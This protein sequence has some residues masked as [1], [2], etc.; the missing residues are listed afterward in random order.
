MQYFCIV[1][2]L[3]C[4]LDML[5]LCVFNLFYRIFDFLRDSMHIDW[6]LFDF[7]LL[8]LNNLLVQQLYL[9]FEPLQ[10]IRRLHWD[11]NQVSRTF[12][13][14]K[15]QVAIR[16]AS[17]QGR[18]SFHWR[19]NRL[20]LSL[21]HV[22]FWLMRCLHL[23]ALF[24]QSLTQRIKSGVELLVHQQLHIFQLLCEISSSLL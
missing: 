11:P 14:D 4:P 17:V 20:D 8:R 24:N 6:V 3:N 12:L 21:E 7:V 19:L 13:T 22:H 18:S 1:L 9:F 10:L 2:H 16:R 23:F 5:R 15:S